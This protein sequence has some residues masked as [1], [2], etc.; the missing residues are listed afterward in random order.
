MPD[1]FVRIASWEKKR[2][3]G[4]G[5][6]LG[7]VKKE[8]YE[9]NAVMVFCRVLP[10]FLENIEEVATAKIETCDLNKTSDR[11]HFELITYILALA[12]VQTIGVM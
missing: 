5:I 12:R 8:I 6:Y 10:P 3:K 9:Y 7:R 2:G 11:P 1:K 4:V